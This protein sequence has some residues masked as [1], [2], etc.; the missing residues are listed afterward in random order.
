MFVACSD[1]NNC[2][3]INSKFE[4]EYAK[5]NALHKQFDEY[6]T[7]CMHIEGYE[8]TYRSVGIIGLYWGTDLATAIYIYDTWSENIDI[9]SNLTDSQQKLI[10]DTYEVALKT[11][12]QGEI[13]AGMVIDNPDC[14]GDKEE[15]NGKC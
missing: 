13:C 1:K 14:L 4:T 7:Q 9:W 10:T 15:F 6:L 5:Y 12:A 2:K 11:R 8:D 3:E